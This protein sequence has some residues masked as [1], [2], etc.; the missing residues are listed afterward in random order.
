MSYGLPP[1]A[2][3]NLLRL[4]TVRSTP[5]TVLMTYTYFSGCLRYVAV[6]LTEESLPRTASRSSGGMAIVSQVGTRVDVWSADEAEAGLVLEFLDRK[7]G[8]YQLALAS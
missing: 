8:S 2:V 4:P 7:I 5:G 1:E 3:V 6:A